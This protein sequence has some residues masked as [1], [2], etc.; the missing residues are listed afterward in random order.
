MV[1]R[2]PLRLPARILA[3]KGFDYEEALIMIGVA[4]LLWASRGAFGR[5][6]RILEQRLN[7]R[8]VLAVAVLVLA[9]AWVGFL[10]H[11]HVEY[12]NDLWWTFAFD[13]HAPRML[14]AT[15]TVALLAAAFGLNLLS[16]T[17]PAASD[18][19]ESVC[20]AAA[21]AIFD[22]CSPCRATRFLFHPEATPSSCTVRAAADRPGIGGTARHR[23]G[24]VLP[25]CATGTALERLHQ[26][27]AASLPISWMPACPAE[28]EEARAPLETSVSRARL[29]PTCGSLAAGVRKRHSRSY[30]RRRPLH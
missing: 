23:T 18:A 24:L 1:A 20:D 13:A 11:R 27:P 14:R 8:W 4:G 5:R 19:R 7:P 9:V 2:D 21:H 26:V 29:V 16:P 22:A 28:G 30:R 15:F 25:W 6:G 17:A 10:S 3:L 12:S